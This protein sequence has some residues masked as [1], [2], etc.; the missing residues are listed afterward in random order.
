MKTTFAVIV[1]L[2]AASISAAPL[3]AR[4]PSQVTLAL[5]NDQTGANAGVTFAADGT[6]RSIK[7]LYGSTSVGTSGSVLASSAQLTAFPQTISCV[8][9]NN[10]AQITT[11]TAQN[12]FVDLNGNPA[13][14]AP[15]NLDN[16]TV[17]CRA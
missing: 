4:G 15:I 10:G 8:I 16:G 1:S 9:K 17:N 13:S 12:T 3:D 5:S 11:L 6:D 7:T 2:L 14:N